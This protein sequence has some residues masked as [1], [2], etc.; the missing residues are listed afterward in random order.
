LNGPRIYVFADESQKFAFSRNKGASKYFILTTVTIMT[1]TVGLALQELQ[2]ELAWEGIGLD[3]AFHATTDKQELRDKVFKTLQ[4]HKFRVDATILAHLERSLLGEGAEYDLLRRGSLSEKQVA[5]KHSARH[6][7]KPLTATPM[8]REHADRHH[9]FRNTNQTDNSAS[10]TPNKSLFS[11][12][13]LENAGVLG[14]WGLGL[15]RNPRARGILIGGRT[16]TENHSYQA[17]HS[18]EYHDP[19]ESLCGESDCHASS[20]RYPGM[21]V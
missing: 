11:P 1:F 5:T 18:T 3:V 6:R 2:G 8:V 7:R 16:R 9:T 4:H 12:P 10:C 20:A 17:D 13:K 21:S 19:N 14:P 15:F